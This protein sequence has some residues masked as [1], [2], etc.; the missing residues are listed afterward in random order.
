MFNPLLE[1]QINEIKQL[2]A[3]Y[4]SLR[5]VRMNFIAAD[6]TFFREL[7]SVLQDL[8]RQIKSKLQEVISTY[9]FPPVADL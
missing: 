2:E 7:D 8:E 3:Q 4:M 5:Q 9:N 6:T 1:Q